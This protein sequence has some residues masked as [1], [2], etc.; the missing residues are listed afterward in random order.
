MK[1]IKQSKG[2]EEDKFSAQ[3]KDKLNRYELAKTLHSR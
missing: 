3:S 1:R 2:A